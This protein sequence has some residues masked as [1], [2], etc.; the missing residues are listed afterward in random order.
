MTAEDAQSKCDEAIKAL[1]KRV[2]ILESR[3]LRKIRNIVEAEE[4]L[5]V[6]ANRMADLQGACFLTDSTGKRT[7][8]CSRENVEYHY[9][10]LE[11]DMWNAVRGLVEARLPTR[12]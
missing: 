5:L 10:G 4:A 2:S 9:K 6:V 12:R 1:Q 11:T 3:D 7:G 8:I